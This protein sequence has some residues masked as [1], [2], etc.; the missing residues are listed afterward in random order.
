MLIIFYPFHLGTCISADFIIYLCKIRLIYMY[1]KKLTSNSL[2]S[3]KYLSNSQ[4]YLCQITKLIWYTICM[5]VGCIHIQFTVVIIYIMVWNIHH[6]ILICRVTNALQVHAV[7]FSSDKTKLD[8]TNRK[9]TE[10]LVPDEAKWGAVVG[11]SDCFGQ[12]VV[13]E[14]IN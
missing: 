12:R 10:N 9:K 13:A 7:V 6:L 8:T 5:I 1:L 14:I 3:Y 11:Q 4:L 2:L